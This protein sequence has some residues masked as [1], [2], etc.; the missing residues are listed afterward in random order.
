MTSRYLDSSFFRSVLLTGCISFLILGCANSSTPS[1][2]QSSSSQT[3]S[4]IAQATAPN[5]TDSESAQAAP[6][7]A[8]TAIAKAAS[9][10][11]PAASSSS[12]A[13]AQPPQAKSETQVAQQGNVI[14]SLKADWNRDGIPDNAVLTESAAEPDQASLL[15][16]LSDSAQQPRLAVEKKNFVWRGGMYGT[17]PSLALNPQGS[18]LITSG[19]DAIGRG[20]WQQKITAMYEDG[21]F[22]VAGYTYSYRDTIDLAA[23]GTCDVNLLTGRGVRNNQEF[24]T[25]LKPMNLADWTEESAPK[26]CRF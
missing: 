24:R 6:E 10:S 3:Q 18:L 21:T 8:D 23:G 20:R 7:K 22:V 14:D 1:A 4:P 9:T 12:S 11:R 2:P 15:I 17:R 5:Q 19:N 25:S 13:P 26:E 16:Y